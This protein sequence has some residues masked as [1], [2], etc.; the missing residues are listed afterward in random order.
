MDFDII[1]FGTHVSK[2]HG[3]TI[4]N[5]LDQGFEVKYRLPTLLT[6]DSEEGISTSAALCS[7]KFASFWAEHRK[8]FDLVLCLGDRFEM[9][10]AVSAG[11]PFG[12]KFA[13][14]CGGDLSLG[15]IDNVYR[16]AL[17]HFSNIHF[18]TTN[19]CGKRVKELK[20]SNEVVEVVGLL[21][22]DDLSS[23]NMC[24]IK[25]FYLRW[26]VDLNLPTI[27][28]TFHPETID[29]GK[30]E[31]DSEIILETFLKLTQKFQLV[32]TLPNADTEGT[33]YREKFVALKEACPEKVFLI[34]NFGRTSYFTCLK[35]CQLVLGNSSSG[36]SEAASFK[37]YTIN[38]GD[39]QKGRETGKNVFHAAFDVKEIT[40]LVSEIM[41]NPTFEGEN[42]YHKEGGVETIINTLKT[43]VSHKIEV[44][45]F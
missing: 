10:A 6:D 28:S 14:L 30:N 17:T 24:S 31:E 23:I 33:V 8:E 35:Y 40:S 32:I 25:E 39:R 38:V 5:I 36:I 29:S 1:A 20:V 4:N 22:L 43:T 21:S 19:K 27:L 7:L 45:S 41:E 3:Y 2:F 12:V 42:I 9:F 15:A 16:D 11:V 34:E 26:G 18:T 44:T 13:H 37:K